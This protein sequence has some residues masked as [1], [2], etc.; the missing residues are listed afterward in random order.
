MP[1]EI[2]VDTVALALRNVYPDVLERRETWLRNAVAEFL[3][4]DAEKPQYPVMW[5]QDDDNTILASMTVWRVEPV[6]SIAAG[7]A[8]TSDESATPDSVAG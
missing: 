7:T 5:L 4:N 3:V 6:M 1:G 2:L 8:G